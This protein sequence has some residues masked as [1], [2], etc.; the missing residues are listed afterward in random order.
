MKCVFAT[1]TTWSITKTMLA[2]KNDRNDKVYGNCIKIFCNSATNLM[3]SR[4]FCMYACRRGQ[5][6]NSFGFRAYIKI[7]YSFNMFKYWFKVKCWTTEMDA[8]VRHYLE[9]ISFI[10][11]EPLFVFRRTLQFTYCELSNYFEWM[12]CTTMQTDKI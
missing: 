12:H 1:I 8:H 3:L 10:L 7:Y 5:K 11:V 9:F 4:C 6:P 2:P